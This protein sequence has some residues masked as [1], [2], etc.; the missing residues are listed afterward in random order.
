[1]NSKKF[2]NVSAHSINSVA[3]EPDISSKHAR[4]LVSGE[5][6]LNESYQNRITLRNTTFMPNII[7][8]PYFMCLL[9]SP[10]IELRVNKLL[11]NRSFCLPEEIC[12]AIC[13][14]G[15]DPETG[16][17]YD[18]DNDID[19]SYIKLFPNFVSFILFSFFLIHLLIWKILS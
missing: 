1:M 9:F 15:F 4:L 5:I 12:G 11:S 6:N 7:D 14:V 19:V 13:G 8:F 3:L 10:F 16:E 2:I 18:A 17:S